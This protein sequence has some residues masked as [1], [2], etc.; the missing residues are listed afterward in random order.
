MNK[1]LVSILSL[2]ALTASIVGCNTAPMMAP[3]AGINPAQQLRAQSVARPS[4][5]EGV[6]NQAIARGLDHVPGEY[7]VKLRPGASASALS[8]GVRSLGGNV[9]P[10]GSARSPLALVTVNARAASSTANTMKALQSNPAVQYV[11]PNYIV[12][13]DPNEMKPA[14]PAPAPSNGRFKPN[15]PMY[16]QQYT[17]KAINSEAG[18]EVQKGNEDFI[19][20]IVDTGVDTAHPDLK[21]KLLPGFNTVDNTDVVDDG[22]GHGTHCAGIAAAITNNG[23]GVAGVAPNVKILP[24]QVLSK[25]GSGSYASVA[26]GI[27]WAA[28]HGAK[29]ISMSLGG[30]RG[31]QVI[32]DAVNHAL[33]KD[34]M[35]IAAMGNSG[36]YNGRKIK[37]YPAATPGVMS[38]GATDSA[39]K[40][41]RF[42]QI[43]EWNSVTAPGVS[44]LSTFPTYSSGMP[45]TNYGSISGTSMATPAVAGLAALV[46]SQ[47][48]QLNAKQVQAHIEATADDLG[49]EGRDNYFGHGRVNVGKALSTS[50]AA[51]LNGARPAPVMQPGVSAQAFRSFRR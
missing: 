33:E 37:S 41:A 9:K 26:G 21:A 12:Q 27:I 22:N 20:A 23:T 39:D 19:L 2:T 50:P 44:I 28:D 42:S 17:H 29:V 48:P 34:A 18:W 43:G 10:L 14:Q 6:L 45:G 3:G 15:D 51:T 13:L 7:I 32:T 35:L 38:V 4:A 46:R 11:E 1:K 24:V 8:S 49:D 31:S 47:F 30:P 16:D 5:R 36:H 40:L 25:S